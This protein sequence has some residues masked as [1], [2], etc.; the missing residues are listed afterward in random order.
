MRD[1]G[2]AVRTASLALASG[3]ALLLAGCENDSALAE[4]TVCEPSTTIYCRCPGGEPGEKRCTSDGQGFGSCEGCS[5]RPDPTGGSGAGGSV[6]TGS[7]GEGA[8][9]YRPC[10]D[11]SQ[12]AS[13]FCSN[14]F[15]TL[16][17]SKVSDCEFGVAEC[18]SF[19]GTTACMPVCASVTDCLVYGAPP[20]SCG[21]AT[22]IDNWSVT[23]CANWG[24]EQ[25]LPPI[26][27]DCAPFDHA[28]CHLGY[29]G[30]ARVCSENG[31]CT[32]G[33]FTSSDCPGGG[34]CS[35]DGATVGEC[36]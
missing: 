36:P 35:S 2:L 13:G 29:A 3:V 4:G 17:C 9:L 26:G 23:V 25:R 21:F 19:A 31:V 7:G 14:G 1:V 11:G 33:C 12:C 10:E 20:S 6:S 24:A 32:A 15:C 34:S 18:V 27:T 5:D 8:P 28:A 16:P 30:R 22:A